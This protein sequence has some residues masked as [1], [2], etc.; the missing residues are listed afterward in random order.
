METLIKTDKSSLN[1]GTFDNI[2]LVSKCVNNIE[3]ELEIRPVIKLYGKTLHQN[4]NVG[5][6]SDTSI[7]YK[8]SNKMMVSKPL[9]FNLNTLLEKINTL[10]SSNYNGIL[11][12]EYSNGNDYIGAHSDDETKL[13]SDIG[14]VSLSFGTTRKFR[15]RDKTTKKI[16]KDI[17][18]EQGQLLQMTGKFQTEFT[19]E[20]PIEKRV[21]ER[22]VSFTFRYHLQ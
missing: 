20:I 17:S 21:K 19:H 18:M 4:R 7:G 11:V 16:V 3:N 5:F 13:N 2:D 12:N 10:F 9:S 14:V 6:F 1:I 8:Y 22:R 15:I